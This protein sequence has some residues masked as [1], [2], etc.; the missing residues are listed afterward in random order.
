PTEESSLPDYLEFLTE[1]ELDSLHGAM[2]ARNR[3]LERAGRL[4]L[5][6]IAYS[7]LIEDGALGRLLELQLSEPQRIE[8]MADLRAAIEGL[9]GI[10]D[11]FERLHDRRPLL[12]DMAVRP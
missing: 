10:E 3:L 2:V 9:G 12:S 11:V 1:A 8:A 5:A 6:A 4:S 7:A